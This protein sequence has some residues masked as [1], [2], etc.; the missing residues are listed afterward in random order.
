MNFKLTVLFG[1]STSKNYS[2]ALKIAAKFS[3]FEPISDSSNIN[4]I[5]IDLNELR[6]KSRRLD[7]L[8]TLIGGWKSSKLFINDEP[9]NHN[10]IR[11]ITNT[12]L[13][14]NEEYYKSVLPDKHCR[15]YNGKEGWG[16]KYL[17]TIYL[18]GPTYYNYGYKQDT[19]WYHF[20][21][22]SS[23]SIWN[24]DKIQLKEALEREISLKYI[25]LCDAFNFDNIE[26]TLSNLPDT[27]D[28]NSSNNWEIVY[29]EL[30]HNGVLE[31]SPVG[32]KPK[33]EKTHSSELSISLDSDETDNI[34]LLDRNIP[35]VTFSDIG[36]ID[37]TIE[38]IREVIELPL[39]RPE[40]FKHLGIK[41][42]K[43]IILYGP[44]G[45][46]K[47]LIAKSIANEVNAHFIAIKGPEL[48]SKWHG[49]SEENLRNVF[50]QARSLQPSIIFFDEIDA[51]AQRRSEEENLRIDSRFVNQ[52]LSLIDGIEVYEN[53]CIIASTNRLELLDEALMRPG[54]FDYHI[55][56]KKPTKEGCHKIFSICIREMPVAPN[57]NVRNFSKKLYGLSGA[58]IAFIAREG[59]YNCL[60][61]SVNLENLVKTDSDVPIDLEKLTITEPDFIKALDIIQNQTKNREK[62]SI[63]SI[64]E[65]GNQ[66]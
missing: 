13:K 31:L 6:E 48:L 60:R 54:R 46:G 21:Y 45:C 28:I 5:E 52:M 39:K 59:A 14:C 11:D 62:I 4:R 12:V 63:K 40:L 8:W 19:Y 36:G 30:L 64:L 22:F 15:P 42:H 34:N 53:V 56:I 23:E 18:S 58:E 43:G 51:I 32:I 10:V 27:I 55:E 2:Q 38:T 44:P 65:K 37:D 33:E 57:F 61:R 49:Q 9:V 41:P 17:N 47:T 7:N 3:N 29:D 26:S 25:Y 24:I 50:A 66:H 35:K 20:G 16:C 1:F